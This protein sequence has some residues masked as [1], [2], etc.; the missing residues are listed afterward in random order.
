MEMKSFALTMGLGVAA[1]AA[2]VLMLP[3]NNKA[4][5][6]A[7]KAANSIENTVEDAMEKASCCMKR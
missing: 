1:G 6:V 5:R 2:A 7:Q 3:R 4:R